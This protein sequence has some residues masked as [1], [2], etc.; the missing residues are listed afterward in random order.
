MSFFKLDQHLRYFKAEAMG[1]LGVDL[2]EAL[3]DARRGL[4]QLIRVWPQGRAIFM[5]LANKCAAYARILGQAQQQYPLERGRFAPQPLRRVIQGIKTRMEREV[6]A[7][8]EELETMEEAGKLDAASLLKYQKYLS[9][10]Y[11]AV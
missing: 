6:D 1:L 8:W 3:E 4:L 10:T 5:S 9:D 11:M 7:A 2:Q